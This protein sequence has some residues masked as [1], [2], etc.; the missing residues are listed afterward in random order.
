MRTTAGVARPGEDVILLNP[1]LR[2]VSQEEV[3]RTLLHELAHLLV[4]W[5]Y[6]GYRVPQHGAQWRLACAQL[7]IP[8]ERA[9]HTLPWEKRRQSRKWQ[10]TCRACGLSIQRV[11]RIKHAAACLPCCRKHNG[12]RFDARFQL[13][14][15]KLGS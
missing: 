15:E 6:E 4:H 11:R 12:G 10:Y 14:E 2:E 1:R 8:G 3:R 13:L 5:R 9:R 7:G